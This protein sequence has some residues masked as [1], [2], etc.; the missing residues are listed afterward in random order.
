MEAGVSL[1]DFS[2][3]LPHCGRGH[4]TENTNSVFQCLTESGTTLCTAQ[5]ILQEG[6]ETIQNRSD[7]N[8]RNRRFG[9]QCS[10]GVCLPGTDRPLHCINRVV[11][12]PVIPAR[13]EKNEKLN[14]L[15]GGREAR[16]MLVFDM[17]LACL[18]CVI[19][20]I[21]NFAVSGSVFETAAKLEIHK[22]T[23]SG[24]RSFC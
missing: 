21:L 5:L 1:V 15:C 24:W 9:R 2:V 16:K 7:K 22:I 18:E 4:G 20:L 19:W 23:F 17:L 3:L 6:L 14:C 12:T 13:K 8:K 11:H 10:S